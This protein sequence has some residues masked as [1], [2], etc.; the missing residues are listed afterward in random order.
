MLFCAEEGAEEG[1]GRSF[2]S[3][4]GTEFNFASRTERTVSRL[5]ILD[6]IW[7][8]LMSQDSENVLRNLV[9]LTMKLFTNNK[10]VWMGTGF[11]CSVNKQYN[12]REIK[13]AS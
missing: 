8:N 4:P 5:L 3:R 7:V 2:V 6:D 13:K 11:I 1:G 10:V 9:V 12:R